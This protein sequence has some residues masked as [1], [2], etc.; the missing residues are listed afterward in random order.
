MNLFSVDLTSEALAPFQSYLKGNVHYQRGVAFHYGV[1]TALADVLS[2]F[3]FS[4]GSC[5]LG[6]LHSFTFL[7][8]Q[9]RQSYF[10]LCAPDDLVC[11]GPRLSVSLPSVFMGVSDADVRFIALRANFEEAFFFLLDVQQFRK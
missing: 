11:P 1:V 8:R 4:P 7:Q 6:W 10:Y 2:W 9:S 3:C 5:C